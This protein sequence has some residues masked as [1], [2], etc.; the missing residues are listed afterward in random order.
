MLDSDLSWAAEG[1]DAKNI[2]F[3]DAQMALIEQVAGAA[4]KETY[5]LFV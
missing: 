5:F 2:S 4:K 1:H 3:T